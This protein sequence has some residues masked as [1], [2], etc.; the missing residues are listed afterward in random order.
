MK[1]VWLPTLNFNY[2]YKNVLVFNNVDFINIER[3][4][5][6]FDPPSC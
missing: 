1:A 2:P 5:T 3:E 4:E 6:Y